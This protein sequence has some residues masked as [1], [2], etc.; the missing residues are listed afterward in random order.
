MGTEALI[1]HLGKTTIGIAILQIYALAKPLPSRVVVLGKAIFAIVV[2]IAQI[3]SRPA[4]TQIHGCL[5]VFL[6]LLSEDLLL[7]SVFL[8][9]EMNAF[10]SSIQETVGVFPVASKVKEKVEH[11]PVEL[12][13]WTTDLVHKPRSRSLKIAQ[14]DSFLVTFVRL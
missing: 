12:S 8:V 4:L 9:I 3:E 5:K 6:D 13:V 14:I 11:L 10:H 2:A 1:H 7:G